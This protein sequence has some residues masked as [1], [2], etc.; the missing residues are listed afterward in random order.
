MKLYNTLSRKKE[1][2]SAP[3]GTVKMYVCG[4]TPYA[5]SHVGHAM[6]SVIF[7]VVR[8][9]LEFQEFE[10]KH[11]QNFTDIDDKMI[12]AAAERGTTTTE[13]AE[14]NIQRYLEEM[15][16]LNVLRAHEYPRATEDMQK[17]LEMIE[18]LVE[19]EFAYQLDGDVYF[20]V[21]SDPGYGKL[22]RRTQDSL[23][24]GARVE[25]NESKEYVMD[26]ALWKAQK[27]GEPA[28][29]SPWGPGRPGWHIEC[30]AM[31]V[32]HLGETFDIHGGGQDLVFPHHENEMAQTEAYTD[33]TQSA[34]FWLHNGLLNID[35]DKM[36]KS[37]GNTVSVKEA[38][39][40]YSS[41]ALR[42]FFLSSHYRSPLVY[43]D[44]NVA[45]QER[46]AKRLRNA[47]EPQDE[48]VDGTPLDPQPYRERFVEAMDDDLNTPRALATLFDAARDINRGRE[49]GRD[50]AQAQN[51][52]RKLAGVLGLTM[53]EPKL[54]GGADIAPF[55]QLLVDTRLELRAA[56]QY[57]LADSIRSQLAELG[58]TLEDTA[59]G[60][61]WRQGPT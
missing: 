5:P 30:S 12:Q 13:L 34:R 23:M 38:L 17:I 11:V 15:D 49:G 21:K 61:E 48:P 41:D 54:A 18:V 22:S 20:R 58:V 60:S 14:E 8:R 59:G 50:V 6:M 9:Y 28:W 36:S 56:K 1:E 55:V 29:E 42:L 52:L 51:E 33:G 40:S 47:L 32:S 44:E 46:A 37:V 27:P 57:E 43:S 3:D 4:V 24:A 35:H 25:V 16:A 19:K 53:H 26:F 31:S 2:F 10:V 45:A 7:D 39:E